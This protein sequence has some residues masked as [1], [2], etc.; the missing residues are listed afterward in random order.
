MSVEPF[1]RIPAPPIGLR[2]RWFIVERRI[3]EIKEAMNRYINA[4]KALPLEWI[5]ELHELL[6]WL[7]NYRA[8]IIDVEVV[9]IE[10]DVEVK[11]LEG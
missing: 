10:I 2:P 11:Q 7:R 4:D 5:E 9:I 8:S 3:L 1:E 6:V